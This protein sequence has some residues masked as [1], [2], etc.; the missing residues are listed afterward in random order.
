MKFQD[1]YLE[2]QFIFEDIFNYD[3]KYLEDKYD[4][5]NKKYFFNKLPKIPI[6]I[7]KMKTKGGFIVFYL[8]GGELDHFKEIVI[9]NF[10]NKTE[11]HTQAILIHE[12]IHAY[13]KVVGM[14]K[15]IGG[16]HGSHFKTIIDKLKKEYDLDIPL[17]DDVKDLEISDTIKRKE[18]FVIILQSKDKYSLSVFKNLTDD[19]LLRLNF[20]ETYAKDKNLK[21]IILRSNNSV[22][23]KYSH[24]KGLPKRGSPFT[25][26]SIDSKSAQEIIDTAEKE[27]KIIKIYG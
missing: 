5:F 24:K 23:L 8:K 18:F 3:V 21:F 26:Y 7:N 9:S 27:N 12:M 11:K 17:E 25:Y 6:R 15:D 2:E 14:V 13:L 22:L 10:F 16:M 1:Y 19:E 4:E 20:L